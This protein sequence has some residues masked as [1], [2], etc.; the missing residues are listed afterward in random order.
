RLAPPDDLSRPITG[1]APKRKPRGIA[2]ARILP[3]S[4]Q[5]C[6]GPPPGLHRPPEPPRQARP[7]SSLLSAGAGA[8]AVPPAP[9]PAPAGPLTFRDLRVLLRLVSR[10]RWRSPPRSA[11]V[12]RA[13]PLR[14][15][16]SACGLAAPRRAGG[17]R[18][19]PLRPSPETADRFPGSTPPIAAAR[20][21]R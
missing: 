6:R 11:S 13:S 9:R 17:P 8:P 14:R 4:R 12:P 21:D 18:A 7:A 20:R 15:G 19:A 3:G 10:S 5:P 16:E 1:G 2:T